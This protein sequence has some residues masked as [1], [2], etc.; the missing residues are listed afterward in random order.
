MDNIGQDSHT[1]F[2]FYYAMEMDVVLEI[3]VA[4]RE[5]D[6]LVGISLETQW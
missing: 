5:G 4:C 3:L 1:H 6:Q 2:S